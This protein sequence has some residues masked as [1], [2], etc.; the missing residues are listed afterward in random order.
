MFNSF[1]KDRYV[2]YQINIT[3]EISNRYHRIV[4]WILGIWL[5]FV[6]N[7][8]YLFNTFLVNL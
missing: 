7:C 8:Y 5:S 6:R 2:E 1:E 4:L 3:I